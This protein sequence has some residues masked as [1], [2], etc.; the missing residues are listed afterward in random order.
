[1]ICVI[2]AFPGLF[3][4]WF[5]NGDPR[6]CNLLDS[7]GTPES[8][9]PFGFDIQGCDLY[10]NVIYGT[11]SS[12]SVAL[13]VTVGAMVIAVVLG[14]L[15]G[16]FRGWV[17]AVI[18]RLMDIFFGFPALVGQIILLNTLTQ[19]TIWT[20]SFVLTIFLWPPFTRVFRSSVLAT[21]SMDY[22]TAAKELGA[23]HARIMYRHVLPNAVSPLVAILSLSIGGVITAEAGLTFLGVG[24]R[25]PSI[26]WGV[27]LNVA[28][29][30]FTT[31]LHLLIFPAA[32]LT[33]TVLAFV[34]LGDGLRD[35]LDPKGR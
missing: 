1:L 25:P 29:R 18:S 16:Y 21:S 10:S 17:D 23:G 20:V 32:F 12:L 14:S 6:V 2:A 24:L 31:D 27:Q 13:I 33:V 35:A 5:G 4:G 26:S 9:H 7:G 34:L 3:A 28:Q 15:A 11:R 19:R 22:I 8:G 30:Y